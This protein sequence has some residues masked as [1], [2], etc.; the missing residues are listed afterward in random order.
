VPAGAGDAALAGWGTD[1]LSVYASRGAA[2]PEAEF[3]GHGG[4][5]RV[6]AVSAD[7]RRALTYAADELVRLFDVPGR[8]LVDGF[9]WRPGAAVTCAA[10]AADG[11]QALLGGADGAL[12]LWQLTP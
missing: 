4:P 12:R 3:G 10:L 11:H 6:M 1:T 7:G 8:R 5:I 2:A 9:P